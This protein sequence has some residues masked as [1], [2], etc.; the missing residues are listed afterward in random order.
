MAIYIVMGGIGTVIGGFYAEGIRVYLTSF[1]GSYFFVRGISF[2]AGGFP[3]EF[4]LMSKKPP[5]INIPAFSGY[6]FGIILFFIVGFK[7]QYYMEEKSKSE[8]QESEDGASSKKGGFI[9][10][11]EDKGNEH[12]SDNYRRQANDMP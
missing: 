1:I 12:K 9:K 4:A 2:Y 8:G 3:D 10:L 6:C 7:V 5:A 11:P